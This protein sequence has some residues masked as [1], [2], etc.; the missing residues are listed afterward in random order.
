MLRLEELAQAA[1]DAW[2]TGDL[3]TAIRE[4]GIHLDEIRADRRLHAEAIS[5]ALVQYAMPSDDDIE[6]DDEP[7]TS[8]GEGGIW[9]Q[10]W[11]WIPTPQATEV[12]HG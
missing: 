9:V 5:R 10:A 2:E 7:M 11:L 6:I 8:A 3:A 12:S 4:L 1:V